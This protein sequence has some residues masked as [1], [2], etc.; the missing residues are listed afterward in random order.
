MQARKSSSSCTTSC[1]YVQRLSSLRT[2]HKGVLENRACY[3]PYEY[4]PDYRGVAIAYLTSICIQKPTKK[5][6][7]SQNCTSQ[8]NH[9]K[10]EVRYGVVQKPK[11][12]SAMMAQHRHTQFDSTPATNPFL[13][14]TV[15]FRPLGSLPATT[16]K[17]MLN[18][19]CNLMVMP[20]RSC[21]PPVV[22]EHYY[23]LTLC[24]CSVHI[25]GRD[26]FG[27]FTQKQLHLF[28]PFEDENENCML[29]IDKAFL[30]YLKARFQ[31]TN[32][33]PC[34]LN[35]PKNT[36]NACRSQ[37]LTIPWRIV[38]TI[39][40]LNDS[41]KRFM[42]GAV[43]G[44]KY[45]IA[46]TLMVLKGLARET[47]F[48]ANGFEAGNNFRS[49]CYERA[50]SLKTLN[51]D[52]GRSF[53][54]PPFGERQYIC[55]HKYGHAIRL[56]EKPYCFHIPVAENSI[57]PE[58]Q[59]SDVYGF[60][61]ELLSM[62]PRPVLAVIM[63]YPLHDSHT[64][65]GI[66]ESVDNPHVFLV[67]QTISNACGTIALLHSIMNN[68]HVLEFKDRSLIDE[69]MARTRDMR[70]SERAAVVEGEERLSKLH[71]NSA[72]KG[73]TEAPPASTKTN[74]HFVCF[75]ENSGQLY[76]LDG[77][78]DLPVLHGRTSRETLLEDA[79]EVV[80]KFMARDPNNVHFTVVALCKKPQ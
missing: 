2:P 16:N 46:M 35:G 55:F 53:F 14:S 7:C 68:E 9:F 32:E 48:I 24:G 78:K 19:E 44:P 1:R 79:C 62:V 23:Y 4:R 58:W 21:Y 76:E 42:N 77:R 29:R 15:P 75:I 73:Q 25:K 18:S 52:Y 67:K 8:P 11:Y 3:Q 33:T 47:C 45:G 71:E 41:P 63:L 59:F 54:N 64:D 28:L 38:T 60:E 22:N 70:P 57:K 51:E 61:P 65:D 30:G 31:M 43:H 26:E 6:R 13:L 40:T 5:T 37:F 17:L 34:A 66:G 69:L 72:A 36:L 56:K 12:G 27:R 80:K 10:H 74:L 20:A 50:S 49:S 39:T